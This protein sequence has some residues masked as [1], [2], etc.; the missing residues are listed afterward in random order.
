MI[1]GLQRALYGVNKCGGQNREKLSENKEN[2]IFL[3]FLLGFSLLFLKLFH[4]LPWIFVREGFPNIPS[5]YP[6]NPLRSF[7]YEFPL[8]WPLLYGVNKCLCWY[9]FST[10]FRALRGSYRG[11]SRPKHP[12][13]WI[14]LLHK[15]AWFSERVRP[16]ISQQQIYVQVESPHLNFQGLPCIFYTFM[17]I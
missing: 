7:P 4:I 2:I 8:L 17:L 15:A 5:K 12:R 14:F 11:P 9:C 6:L 3:R 16:D 10:T 13:S 1:C